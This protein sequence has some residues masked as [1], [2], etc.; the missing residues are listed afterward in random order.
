MTQKNDIQHPLLRLELICSMNRC[1]HRIRSQK[2][3]DKLTHFLD[4]GIIVKLPGNVFPVGDRIAITNNS[5][6]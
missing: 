2:L 1:V 6:F 5:F 4:D 3:N